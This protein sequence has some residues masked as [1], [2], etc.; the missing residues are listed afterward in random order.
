M[1]LLIA[2]LLLLSAASY[3]CAQDVSAYEKHWFVRGKDTLPYRLLLPQ[4]YDKNKTYPVLFFLH[5]SGERGNDNTKQLAHGGLLFLRD[6]VREKYPAIIIFPQCPSSSYWSN[7]RFTYDSL[8]QKRMFTFRNGGKPTVAMELLQ[9]LVK[10]V[11]KELPVNRQ[12]VYVGGL[13]MGGMGTFELARRSPKVFAAAFAICGGADT[14][15]AGAIRNIKWRIFHGGKD[16]VVDPQFSVDMTNALK[17]KGADV[18]LTLYPEANHNSWDAT[19]AEPW[20]L[21][22]LF[23]Q[24]K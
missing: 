12:Q 17:A 14:T 10:Q 22:W 13:S 4:G 16:D 24:H 2:C 21:S 11:L 19:F 3:A 6:S 1:R 5:G 20:L 18:A 9:G 7:A 23:A 8:Q 15:T